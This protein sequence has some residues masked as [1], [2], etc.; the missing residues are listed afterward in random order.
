M[1]ASSTDDPGRPAGEVNGFF[2]TLRGAVLTSIPAMSAL[3]FVIVAV[4]VFRASMM[5]ITTTVAIVSTADVIALLKGVILTLL[6][7]FLAGLTAVSIW[8]WAAVLPTRFDALSSGASGE[9][10]ELT[11]ARE[12]ASRG[13]FSAQAIFA[14]AMLVMAFFTIWWPV[15]LVLLVPALATTAALLVQIV[16]PLPSGASGVWRLMVAVLLALLVI[17]AVLVLTLMVG[18]TWLGV[19]V[20]LVPLVVILAALGFGRSQKRHVIP[21]RAPMRVFGLVAA[22]VFVGI[23]TLEPSVWLPLRTITFVG[24]PPVLKGQ[25]LNRQVA[26]YVLS[27]DED[28]VSLLL[29]DPRAVIEV[30]LGDVA[31]AMPLCV[32]P[33]ASG[34]IVTLRASQLLRLDADPH[35]PYGTCPGVEKK[36]L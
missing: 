5:E 32:P 13:L 8:W 34:R 31:P 33:E 2:E 27:S 10:N 23:L 15:F 14:W 12:E 29:N 18:I 24:T 17:A 21:L 7:G 22:A 36:R 6:P 9:S 16:P 28:S 25:P 11:K 4:K 20:L 1:K 35:S 19:V 26:A 3:V 30:K